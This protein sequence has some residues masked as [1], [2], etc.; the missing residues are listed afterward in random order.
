MEDDRFD[1]LY[2]NVANTARGIEPLLDTVFSFLRRKTDFFS[3]PPG[4]SSDSD[5]GTERAKEK[6]LQVLNKHAALY[7]AD[8]E[9]KTKKAKKETTPSVKVEKA[10]A[11]KTQSPTPA[12]TP[13]EEEEDVVELGADGFDISS[14]SASESTT[15]ATKTTST[16]PSAPTAAA[17]TATT[18]S[19]KASDEKPPPKAK[20]S[21]NENENNDND[22]DDDDDGEAPI[23]NGGAVPDKYVWTQTL[24]ELTITVPLPENTRSKHLKVTIAK[25]KLHIQHLEH[26]ICDNEALTKPIIVDDSF[27]TIEDGNKLVLTLQKSNTMEWWDSVCVNDPKIN[28]KKVQPENSNLSDLEGETRQT[29]EKMMYDQRQKALGLPSSEEQKKM[30]IMEKFM[31]QHPEM[32]FSKAKIS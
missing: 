29:V 1:G 25:Q 19:P 21:D 5:I 4:Q 11:N 3:G 13:K 12:P 10:A 18:T 6:V 17:A 7:Q 2:M 15:S 28:T 23:G 8:I 9:K 16:P 27:W 31:K 32:D 14:A 26:K 30:D 22:D 20:T 24:A